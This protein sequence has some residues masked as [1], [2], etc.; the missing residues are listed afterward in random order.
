MLDLTAQGHLTIH[1]EKKHH[2]RMPRISRQSTLLPDDC[3]AVAR[4]SGAEKPMFQ[5]ISANMLRK[6]QVCLLQ[7]L[8]LLLSQINCASV[9][10]SRVIRLTRNLLHQRRG[11]QIRERRSSSRARL[12]CV[13]RQNECALPGVV[14][15]AAELPSVPVQNR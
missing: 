1:L 5:S 14:Q 7:L 11:C 8:V 10:F 15:S 12:R 6:S 9:L 2:S 3:F 13:L 4:N